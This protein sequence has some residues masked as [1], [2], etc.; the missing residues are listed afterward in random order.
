M[1]GP[2]GRTLRRALEILGS[3][4]R[5]ARALDVSPEALRGYLAQGE[6]I[7]QELFIKA[8]DIVARA[9]RTPRDA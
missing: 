6:G 9:P 1:H 8:L 3:E 4:E 5:L 2:R 7:P